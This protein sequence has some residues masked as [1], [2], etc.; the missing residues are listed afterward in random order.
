MARATNIL[1]IVTTQWR[2]QAMG[3]SG[4]SNAHTPALDRFAAESENFVQAVTP[5]P[6]GPFA[7]AAMLTGIPSPQNG[8]ADYYDPLPP[9]AR[10]VAH[11]LNDRGY[12]TAFFG[13]W[14]L[15][16]RDR[17][18]ALVGDAH[19]RAIV[20]SEYRGGFSFFEG[21]EGGFLLNDPW[22][23]GT[24]L[25]EP[26]RFSGYQS[27]VLCGRA[28]DYLSE[29]SRSGK[30]AWFAVVSLE[31][32][33]PPYAAPAAGVLPSPPAT[34]ELRSN[35]PRGG[36]VEG[37]ARQ[38]LSGYYAHIAATDRAIGRLLRAIDYRKTTVVF[39]SVHGDMHG[40]HGFFRKGW[41]YE[42][43]VRI[44][45]LVRHAERESA[46]ATRSEQPVSLIDLREFTLAVANGRGEFPQREHCE[47]SMPAV[48]ALP[49]QCDRVWRG[50]R[51]ARWKRIFNADGSPWMEFDL[52]Q[53]PLEENNLI[54]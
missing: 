33:H 41:P 14:H 53:D 11:D 12:D 27:D 25:A 15:A 43:S 46:R 6:F 29:K 31:A 13:K 36:A 30:D 20:P 22:L 21:F 16:P 24:R 54:R 2:A 40:S 34:L 44:P 35:V 38:E 26:Q 1:W 42:E 9:M 8:I 18:A 10:T 17:E 48:V 32:P 49:H 23:H 45:L 19:A 5:H 7:R 47:I 37:R 3:Y 28:A 52:E 51:S 4:D 50:T 39:T